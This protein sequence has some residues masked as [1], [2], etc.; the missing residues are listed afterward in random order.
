[1]NAAFRQPPPRLLAQDLARMALGQLGALPD[2]HAAVQ[3]HRLHA[4]PRRAASR[5]S[6]KVSSR[7]G[8]IDDALRAR[9][10]RQLPSAKANKGK[11]ELPAEL[12]AWVQQ[13]WADRHRGPR[14]RVVGRRDLSLAA[15]PRRRRLAAAQPAPTARSNTSAP[16]AAGFPTST[17]CTRAA[18]PAPPGAGSSTSSRLPRSC[19]RSPACSFSRCTRATARSPGPMVGMGL[20]LPV[21][22]ALLFIH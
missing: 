4:Q 9:L 6:R 21:L 16:T 5:P 19:S 22:L 15:A 14:G 10:A 7:T 2:R 18:T 1:M 13:Q 17:T 11:A 8:A 3:R 12:Q 20:V